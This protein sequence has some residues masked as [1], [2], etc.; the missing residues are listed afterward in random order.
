MQ[1][2]RP[3]PKPTESETL[4]KGLFSQALHVF[5]IHINLEKQ[6]ILNVGGL[7]PWKPFVFG[8]IN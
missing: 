2:L 6:W 7:N 4:G 1:I 5:Q 8:Q 3:Q